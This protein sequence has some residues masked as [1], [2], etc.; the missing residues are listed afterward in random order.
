MTAFLEII[1][2]QPIE[3]FGEKLVYGGQRF[4]PLHKRCCFYCLHIGDPPFYDGCP[5]Y[6]RPPGGNVVF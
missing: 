3:N 1:K 2:N 5:Y 6:N 4:V